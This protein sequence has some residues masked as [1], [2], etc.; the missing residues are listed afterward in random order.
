MYLFR[1]CYEVD[2]CVIAIILLGKAE[3][4]LIVDEKSICKECRETVI[5][6]PAIK[7][8]LSRKAC[9]HWRVSWT[10]RTWHCHDTATNYS[11]L[12]VI[13]H[14]EWKTLGCEPRG[15]REVACTWQATASSLDLN[16][17]S[18]LYI[19]KNMPKVVL[20]QPAIPLWSKGI[21]EKFNS[22]VIPTWN[23]T[24][25]L[26]IPGFCTSAD[27]PGRGSTEQLVGDEASCHPA[28]GH[29]PPRHTRSSFWSVCLSFPAL[30]CPG[31]C[32]PQ[33]LVGMHSPISAPFH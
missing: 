31:W 28:P 23:W 29:I 6:S 33:P 22:C 32:N 13:L 10:T 15:G 5:P 3:G 8:L 7:Q 30:V 1:C 12:H 21:A 11:N 25:I 17:Y 27:F 14:K 24:M 16:Q 18:Y 20:F 9:C 2:C 19:V 4:E 26:P